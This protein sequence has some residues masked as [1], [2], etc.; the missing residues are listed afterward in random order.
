MVVTK[1]VRGQKP[2]TDDGSDDNNDNEKEKEAEKRAEKIQI[3]SY[4][5]QKTA[6][7]RVIAV[8]KSN[9]IVIHCLRA[10]VIE[11]SS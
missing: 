11:I 3:A 8:V 2:K 5:G 10:I 4:D 7:V 1:T 6:R 9:S